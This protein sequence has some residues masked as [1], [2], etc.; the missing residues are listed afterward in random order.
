MTQAAEQRAPGLTHEHERYL[1]DL[2]AAFDAAVTRTE[3]VAHDLVFAGERIRIEQAGPGLS[4]VIADA[5]P[6]EPPASEPPSARIRAWDDASTGSRL[7]EFPWSPT[8]I[9]RQGGI[10]GWNVPGLRTI[11]HGDV[12]QRPD[13]GFNA[14][15]MYDGTTRSGLFWVSSPERAPWFEHVEPLR[16]TLHWTLAAC[17]R[18]MLHAAAVATADGCAILAGRGWAGKTTTTMACVEAGLGFLGDNYVVLSLVD[19]RPYAHALYRNIKLRHASI[20]LLPD[21]AHRR[22]R[23]VGDRLVADIDER[24]LVREAPVAV[25][26]VVALTGGETRIRRV[27]AT[28][29]LLALAPS[30]IYQLPINDGAA[31]RAMATLLKSVPAYAL[32]LG[33][34]PSSAPPVIADAIGRP[35]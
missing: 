5:L 31:L 27:S 12:T 13:Y 15:S 9:G 1:A 18:H 21:L 17:D 19:E 2:G 8:D 4:P 33:P 35:R 34:D 6:L 23:P 20:D 28:E 26:L 3:L 22:L 11:Y 32:E 25:V 16:P 10:A 30:T 24:E 29:A 7:P 14:F